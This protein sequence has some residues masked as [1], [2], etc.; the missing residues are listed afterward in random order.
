MTNCA[1]HY[2][3]QLNINYNT[4]TFSSSLKLLRLQLRL[5]TN[6]C[7]IKVIKH[8]LFGTNDLA[9]EVEIDGKTYSGCLTEKE[10]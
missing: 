5:L 2:G 10:Q 9:I 7:M 4:N 6:K 3:K 8:F 1:T